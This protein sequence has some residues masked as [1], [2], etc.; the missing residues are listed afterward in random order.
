[1]IRFQRSL[2]I[3]PNRDLE[4][5]TWSK[6][7]TTFLNGKYPETKVQV[8]AHRFGVIDTIAWELDVDNLAS[9]DKY[10]KTLN[11]DE[12]YLAKVNETAGLFM[13]GSLFDTVLENL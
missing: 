5:I 13:A 10:Q 3:A 8:F 6:E 12:E 1:M 2:R 11:A 9:L 4:A 7:I